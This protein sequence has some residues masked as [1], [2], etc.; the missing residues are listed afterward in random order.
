MRADPR[1]TLS[2]VASQRAAGDTRAGAISA[3]GSRPTGECEGPT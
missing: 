3:A 1:S 2:Q